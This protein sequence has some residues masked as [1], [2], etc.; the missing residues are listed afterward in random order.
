MI[1]YLSMALLLLAALPLSAQQTS[2]STA[3]AA[4][5]DKPAE[6]AEIFLQKVQADKKFLVSQNMGLTEAEAKGFWPVY[7]AYQKDLGVINKKMLDTVSA[8]ADAFNA[9]PVGD[10]TAKK[11]TEQYLSVE[12][13]EVNIKKTYAQK[14]SGKIGRAHV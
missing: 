3:P 7:E 5:A 10:D 12:Q 9:G 11:L 13:D 6:N 2:T 1:R 8:F 14:L 4:K